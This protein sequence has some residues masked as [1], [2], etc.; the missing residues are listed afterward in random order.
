MVL[1][2]LGTAGCSGQ[3]GTA[4]ASVESCTQFGIAAIEHHVTVTSLPPACQGLTGTQI[5]SA[6]GTALRSAG[7]GVRTKALR[8]QSIVKAS[9]YLV[10]MFVAV[11]AQRGEPPVA[12]SATAGWISR[13]TLGLIALCTWLTTVALGLAM[14][15]R[16]ILRRRAHHPPASRLRRP[17]AL[18]FAHL[19]LALASLLIWVAYLATGMTALAWTASGL[20]T[21]VIGL[22]MSLVFLSPSASP[23][24]SATA[25]AL[26]S[27]TTSDSARKDTSRSGHAPVFTTGAHII[28]ATATFL[29][30]VLTAIGS[31]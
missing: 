21:L 9:R 30:A 31:L 29:F 7:A 28:L 22:G 24:G 14:M 3:P 2:A 6:V 12:A 8:R 1:A 20:L 26:L 13:T 19:G 4:E 18:N 5:N 27:A 16:G 23:A 10:H 17:P 15:I 25:Q 11:P